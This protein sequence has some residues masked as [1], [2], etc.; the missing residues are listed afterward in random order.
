WD[1]SPPTPRIAASIRRSY[2]AWRPSAP[3]A[4][5]DCDG[6]RWLPPLLPA[7]RA[8]RC[9]SCDSR[10]HKRPWPPA[11]ARWAFQIRPSVR[12]QVQMS[13]FHLRL[14]NESPHFKDRD[15]R[16]EPDKYEEEQG[17]KAHGTYEDH[18]VPLGKPVHTP[19]AGNKVALQAH[20]HDHKSL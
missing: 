5:R 17:E 15:G 11:P 2:P 8:C 7:D 18:H 19:R 12:K 1:N 14:G 4:E 6:H 3:P 10:R 13:F 20:D 9:P 16:H